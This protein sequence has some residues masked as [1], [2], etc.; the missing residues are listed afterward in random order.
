MVG[1]RLVAFA[2]GVM[3]FALVASFP[4]LALPPFWY[5]LQWLLLLLT[6]TLCQLPCCSFSLH[7]L[8]YFQLLCQLLHELPLG[9][10]PAGALLIED[11]G[12]VK[13]YAAHS[14]PRAD[15][16]STSPPLP[17]TEPRLAYTL[18]GHPQPAKI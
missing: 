2:A 6:G 9:Y 15:L 10:F 16:G 3:Y 12:I 1:I 14:L 17:E 7:E 13:V 18:F 11:V 5:M 8:S 4:K